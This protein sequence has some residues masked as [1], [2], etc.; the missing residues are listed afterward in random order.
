MKTMVDGAVPLVIK[1]ELPLI[2]DATP[3]AEMTRAILS[4]PLTLTLPDGQADKDQV[5]PWIIDPPTLAKLLS[6]EIVETATGA[7]YRVGLD[8]AALTPQLAGLS[9]SLRLPAQNTRFMFNDDTLQLDVIQNSVTGRELNVA[10]SIESIQQKLIRGEHT[11]P[12]EFVFTTPKV[13]DGMTGEQLGIRE[14]VHSETSFFYG[15]SAER[16]QNIQTASSRFHGVLVAPGET[17]SMASAMGDISLDNGYTEALIIF[18]GQTIKGVGGGV[19]QVSTTLFR[20][21]FFSGFPIEERHPHAYRVYYYEKIAGNSINP[22]LA[23][24]DAT[25]F[26]PMVD[27]KFTNDTPYWLLMETYVN[28]SYSSIEWKFYSTNDGR[29]VD[30]ETTGPVN[31]IPAPKTVYRENPELPQGE[32]KQMDWEAD[33]AEVTVERTVRRGD[34][35]L[36]QDTFYTKYEPWQAVYEYGP[37]TEGMPP[38]EENPDSQPDS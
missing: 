38:P 27:F 12:L 30:W 22:N 34:E 4:Q 28:P 29:A 37:G 23:G 6:F 18:G 25:V 36:H 21:A 5:H 32:V 14:V 33:G 24:L 2:T 16:I 31:I 1:E 17:F 26:I 10:A 19:C 3:Q 15:S 13:T 8:A 9:D 11:I 35:I 7:E 20:A